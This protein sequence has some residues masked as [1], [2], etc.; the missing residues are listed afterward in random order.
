MIVKRPNQA[1]LIMIILLAITNLGFSQDNKVQAP[2]AIENEA[3]NNVDFAVKEVD[4]MLFFN[5]R[6]TNDTIEGIFAIEKTYDG[7][8]FLPIEVRK[9]VP[10]NINKPI[11][12]S[13]S[14]KNP[15]NYSIGYRLVKYTQSGTQQL[16]QYAHKYEVGSW[17]L[18]LAETQEDD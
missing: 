7:K 10:N 1:I 17:E 9:N 12:Y 14:D 3:G 4:G 8:S 15:E 6:V 13:F 5:L 18:Q 11:L 16:A 2:V